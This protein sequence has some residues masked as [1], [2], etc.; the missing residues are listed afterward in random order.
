MECEPIILEDGGRTFL[1]NF[2]IFCQIIWRHTLF[3]YFFTYFLSY[4][5]TFLL[6]YLLIYLLHGA[7]SFLRSNRFS[8]RQE[9]PRILWIPKFQ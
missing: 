6:T 3:T 7:K 2:C 5:L 4:L 8:A 9:I 1:R